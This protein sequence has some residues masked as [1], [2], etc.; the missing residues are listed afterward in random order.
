VNG[1]RVAK[2]LKG[3]EGLKTGQSYIL[4]VHWS[5]DF[6]AYRLAG[7]MSGAVLVEPELLVRPLGS[8]KGVTRLRGT[9]LDTF[10]EEVLADQCILYSY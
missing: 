3:S 6:K 1:H 7:G 2:T 9:R 4:F 8:E 10:L 5:R